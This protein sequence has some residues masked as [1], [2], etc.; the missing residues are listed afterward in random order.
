MS[1]VTFPSTGHAY[2]DDGTSTRDMQ[3][4]GH[5]E[6]LLPMLG[7]TV[8]TAQIAIDAAAQASQHSSDA[9][10]DREGAA[11]EHAGAAREHE[12]AVAASG[13]AADAAA[14]A[15]ADAA[16]VNIP[17]L[18]GKSGRVLGVSANE[19]GM[20]WTDLSPF[21]KLDDLSAP[22]GAGRVGYL[23]PAV[24]AV[25]GTAQE[26]HQE[27]RS[28]L[29]FMTPAEKADVW[30]ANPIK[31]H[32]SAFQKAFA[33]GVPLLIPPIIANVET[34]NL[35][36]QLSIMSMNAL[37]RDVPNSSLRAM[38]T[39]DAGPVISVS[40]M[41]RMRFQGHASNTSKRGIYLDGRPVPGG[42]NGGIWWSDFDGVYIAGFTG[43]GLYIRGSDQTAAA[44]CPQ[45]FLGFKGLVVYGGAAEDA[46]VMEGKIG[47]CHFDRPQIEGFNKLTRPLMMK[48]R[49][50]DDG[51][52]GDSAPYAINF[53]V[54]TFQ[55]GKEV[56]VERGSGIV[57]NSSYMENMASGYVFDFSWNNCEINR[58]S[59]SNVFKGDGTG[60]CIKTLAAVPGSTG[61][62]R[63]G[64]VSAEGTVELGLVGS[65]SATIETYGYIGMPTSGLT[66][67]IGA[68]ATGVINAYTKT[69]IVSATAN[70]TTINDRLYAG[71]EIFVVSN[72]GSV[73]YD[74]TDNIKLSNGVSLRTF[75]S[76]TVAHFVKFDLQN[77]WTLVN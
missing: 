38:V 62:L 23:P 17:L 69:M 57:F 73:S 68:A 33:A 41:G 54:P 6:Y 20:E 2:S 24:G 14:A 65:N 27:W 8:A 5:T 40:I 45:Q 25:T 36:S 26:K 49:I 50:K 22:S 7:E 4:G 48:R 12:A 53:T 19:A 47:Q 16:R 37:I 3:D 29:D 55:T 9:A 51:S 34:M 75:Q 74:S 30:T 32:T 70:I 76:G 66:R 1:K 52:Q 71:S 35:R 72:S 39:H 56:R 64:D 21:A 58:G 67:Q 11:V 42:P 43:A 28:V 61:R 18:A 77:V 60:F 63:V 10:A 59:F 46:V 31:D 15:R 44:D 13:A